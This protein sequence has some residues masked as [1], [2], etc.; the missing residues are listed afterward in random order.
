M[1]SFRTYM[2]AYFTVH[3]QSIGVWTPWTTEITLVH[4]VEAGDTAVVEHISVRLS[5]RSR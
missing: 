2:L 5:F 3:E 4:T 1:P